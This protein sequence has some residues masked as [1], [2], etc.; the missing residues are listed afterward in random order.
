M[1]KE[2]NCMEA[3]LEQ[4]NS[5]EMV[6]AFQTSL[7]HAG[8]RIN[9]VNK[10]TVIKELQSEMQGVAQNNELPEMNEME[11]QQQDQKVS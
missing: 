7:D 10:V 8:E 1:L 2:V 9:A 3:L 5:K 11:E 6:G 4:I